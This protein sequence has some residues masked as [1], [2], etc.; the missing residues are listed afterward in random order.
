MKMEDKYFQTMKKG[1]EKQSQVVT[2][3]IEKWGMRRF[4]CGLMQSRVTQGYE[5]HNNADYT[6]MLI[7][8]R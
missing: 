3:L 8:T 6:H 4:F 2:M 5:T 7:I 1:G